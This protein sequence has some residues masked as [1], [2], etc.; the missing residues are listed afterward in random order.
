[1]SCPANLS[2]QHIFRASN[3]LVFDPEYRHFDPEW[4]EGDRYASRLRLVVGGMRRQTDDL[5]RCGLKA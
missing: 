3:Y 5:C 1:M 2:G 4:D